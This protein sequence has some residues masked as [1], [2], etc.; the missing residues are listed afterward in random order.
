MTMLP[1]YTTIGTLPYCKTTAGTFSSGAAT[2]AE[3]HTEVGY[4]LKSSQ[5]VKTVIRFRGSRPAE[6]SAL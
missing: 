4:A 1:V 3:L 6:R 5:D 2:T